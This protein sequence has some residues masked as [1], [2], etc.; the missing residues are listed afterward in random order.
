MNQKS[1]FQDIVYNFG[2]S[3][4]H[5]RYLAVSTPGGVELDQYHVVRPENLIVESRVSHL[6]DVSGVTLL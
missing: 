3:V 4:K 5:F 6:H 1:L 2:L